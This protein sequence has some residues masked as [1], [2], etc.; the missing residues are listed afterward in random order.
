MPAKDNGSNDPI[1]HAIPPARGSS[2][3]RGH[4]FHV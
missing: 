4:N 1:Y 2:T 3:G